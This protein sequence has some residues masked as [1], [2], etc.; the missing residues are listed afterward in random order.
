MH[1]LYMDHY[2]LQA[3]HLYCENILV[4]DWFQL[5]E[6]L[7][8]KPKSF[9]PE[10]EAASRPT[11]ETLPTK[12]LAIPVPLNF[13]TMTEKTLREFVAPTV[14][15]VL[16]VNLGDDDFDLKTSLITIA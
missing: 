9:L 1:Y 7:Q 15:N 4:Y 5:T 16:Q 13:K 14:D 10:C 3:N 11:K 2:P 12:K 6:K 8:G